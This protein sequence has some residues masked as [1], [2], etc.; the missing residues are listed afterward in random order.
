MATKFFQTFKLAVLKQY[1][2]RIS[3][4]VHT[5]YLFGVF[6]ILE[7][8]LNN[9][10]FYIEF[11]INLLFQKSEQGNTCPSSFVRLPKN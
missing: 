7:R 6:N 3:I 8:V 11:R 10:H 5:M 1:F 9:E 4:W 2:S